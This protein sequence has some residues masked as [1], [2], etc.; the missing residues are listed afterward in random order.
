MHTGFSFKEA[1][2]TLQ[3]KVMRVKYPWYE[4]M[5]KETKS[6]AIRE[7]LLH[8][9]RSNIVSSQICSDKGDRKRGWGGGAGQH[10]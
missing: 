8:N 2:T 6:H 9:T 4:E 7:A 3:L 1:K 10:Q 5:W